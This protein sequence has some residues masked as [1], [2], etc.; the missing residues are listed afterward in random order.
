MSW[1]Y[2]FPGSSPVGTF[3][4]REEAIVA[5]RAAQLKTGRV[6]T[7]VVGQTKPLIPA[8]WVDDD[9]DWMLEA[10]EVGTEDYTCRSD[11]VV[12]FVPEER[13]DEAQKALHSALK[14]WA[15]QYVQTSIDWMIDVDT[16]EDVP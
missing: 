8:H 1:W 14:A 7:L 3:A 4:T 11:D 15:A 10:M 5:G 6:Q 16:A 9:L 12:F 13:R 2:G